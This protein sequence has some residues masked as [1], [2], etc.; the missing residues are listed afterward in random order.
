MQSSRSYRI[1]LDHHMTQQNIYERA[2]KIIKIFQQSAY[3]S[4][5]MEQEAE[6]IDVFM[7]KCMLKSEKKI[8]TF[9]AVDYSP[10]KAK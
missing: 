4:E 9:R 10:E 8:R 3:F 2:N 5:R 7:T 1:D 6:A